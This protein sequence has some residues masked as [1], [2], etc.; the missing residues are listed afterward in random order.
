MQKPNSE[1]V[2]VIGELADGGS[3]AIKVHKIIRDANEKYI[4]TISQDSADPIRVHA[5]DGT[6]QTVRYG[7]L[8]EDD[9][10]SADN[11]VQDYLDCTAPLKNIKMVTIADYTFILNNEVECAMTTGRSAQREDYSYVWVKRHYDG[12]YRLT[13]RWTESGTPNTAQ[14]GN[15]FKTEDYKGT[16]DIAEYFKEWANDNV[17]AEFT[18]TQTGSLLRFE[19]KGAVDAFSTKIDTSDPYGNEAMFAINFGEVSGSSRLP[20][21]LPNDDVIKVGGDS[22][23]AQDDYY[24]QYDHDR[25]SWVETVKPYLYNVIDPDT[26]PHKL[27]RTSAGEFTF[28]PNLWEDRLVG[29]EDSAPESSFIGRVI[30]NITFHKNRLWFLAGD[31]VVSSKASD[32]LNLWPGT[33]LDVL[34]DGPIDIAGAGENVTNFRSSKGF[35]KGL[36]LLGD[37]VQFALTAGDQNFTPKSVAMDS[38]TEF[39][40]DPWVDPVKVGP[41][42]YFVCPNENFEQIRE[43]GIQPDTLIQDAADITAHVAKYIPKGDI[44]MEACSLKDMLFINS[45]AL[46][47]TMYVY[48][49]FW[50]GNEKVQ[51]QWMKWNWPTGT[52][53][54]GMKV[55]GSTLYVLLWDSVNEYILEKIELE[56]IQT[57]SLGMRIG[58]DHL[59]SVAG[60]DG[61]YSSG[62]D[63]TTYTLDMNTTLGSWVVVSEDDLSEVTPKSLS[64][65][66][67]ILEGDTTGT[68]HK[69][70]QAFTSTYQFSEWY[71]KDKEGKSILQ[72][73]LQLRQMTLSFKDTGY[74]KIEVTAG[75]RTTVEQILSDEFTSL[76]IGESTVG[77]ITLMTG[78]KNFLIMAQSKQ[79]VIQLI[80][81]SYLPFAIQLGG[82]D[83]TFTLRSPLM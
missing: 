71:A 41:D 75:G 17:S 3:G 60:A 14:E 24:M 65:T 26:V 67:L 52:H 48:K 15:T 22:E 39:T 66:T 6:E 63:D 34:D 61:S 16:E 78:E 2:K 10:F 58:L 4:V 74:F 9:N 35:E 40:I 31:N 12:K 70:G 27:V 33:V 62:N 7:T 79:T 59:M 56:N 13:L 25:K 44:Q 23:T 82:W 29:D 8:D 1:V 76:K 38:T 57:D 83:A 45:S 18:C 50:V 73:R 77:A 72:G 64:G 30:N 32:Y 43:Y 68:D 5:I 11:G 47:N 51:S 69:I 81:D 49:F 36:L 37:E 28:A 54:E 46:P 80:S 20:A 42:I 53:I 19:P 55:F 21:Q